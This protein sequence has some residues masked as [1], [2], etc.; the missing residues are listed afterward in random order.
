MAA[1]RFNLNEGLQSLLSSL[2]DP[3]RG[4][5]LNRDSRALDWQIPLR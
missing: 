4:S 2:G 1:N 3:W 5:N